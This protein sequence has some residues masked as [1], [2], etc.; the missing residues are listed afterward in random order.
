MNLVNF[1]KIFILT[2][3]FASYYPEESKAQ[4]VSVQNGLNEYGYG[5]MFGHSGNCY[6]VLPKHVAGPFPRVTISTAAPV[7][8]ATATIVTP[9]WEG[10]DMALGVVRGGVADRCSRSLQDLEETR[11]S[12]SARQVDLIRLNPN[13]ELNQTT[14]SVVER[15]YLTFSAEVVHEADTITQGSS[16]S[17]AFVNDQPVGM[18]ITSADDRQAT[19]IRAGEL[20]INLQRYLE[21]QGGAYL[22]LPAIAETEKNDPNALPLRYID[23][24]LRA[25]NPMYAPENIVGDGD[26]VFAPERLMS[27]SVGFENIQ[28]VT[29]FTLT[30]DVSGGYALPKEIIVNWSTDESGARYR[31]WFRGEVGPDGIFD[32]GNLAPRNLR[33]LQVIILNTW[34]SGEIV[35][36]DISVF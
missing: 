21:E 6:V 5:W 29:R 24:S 32:T 12:A 1:G 19:F 14:L 30:S 7:E 2:L 35:L 11:R 26:F 8:N 3:I 28:S 27:L 20:Y 9:F 10:I 17:F 31:E 25:V 16:G 4:T 15:S 36:S 18:A 22:E 33:R 34:G 13:G 23:T